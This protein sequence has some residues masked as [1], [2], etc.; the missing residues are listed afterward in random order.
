MLQRAARF[1]PST[2]DAE[3]RT[4][5]LVWST[6][7]GV[8]RRD[9]MTGE[10]FIEELTMTADAV[11]LSRLNAG[12]PLLAAH[13]QFALDGTLGVVER[14]WIDGGEGR[15]T[16][17]FSKR[18][19]VEDVLQD[20]RDGILRNVSVGYSVEE[21]QRER[22]G[23]T[24]V[25][26]AVRWTPMEIS[27]VPVPADAKAQVRS[28][29]EMITAQH[30]DG[31]MPDD[32]KTASAG[33]DETRVAEQARATQPSPDE[34]RAQERARIASFEAPVVT[35]RKAGL[36][37]AAL[38]T[39]RQS[40][41]E[42]G[43]NAD[44]LQA[45]LFECLAKTRA[46]N[47][48]AAAAPAA[49]IPPV[50]TVQVGHSYDDPTVIVDAMATAIAARSMDVVRRSVGDG[51]W[52]DYASLRPSEMLMELAQARGER[53]SPRDRTG[54]IERAFHTTSDF[55]LLLENAGNKMLEAGYSLADPSYR[56][57][58]ARRRFND[59]KPHSFL[60][61]GDYP[62]PEVLGE[63]AEIKIGTMSEKR[64]QITPRTHARG[65]MVTRQMLVNDDLGAFTDFSAMIGRRIA[66]YENA[67]AYAL[68]NTA[69]GDGP[70]L[71]EGSAAVFTTGRNNKAGSATAVTAAALG[72]GFN[73]IMGQTS[74]DG[75]KLNLAPRFLVCSLSQR[76]VAQQLAA[77]SVVPS[78]AGNVNVF[79]GSFEVVADANIPNHRWYLFADPAAA[80]VY[81]YGYVGDAEGPMM[82]QGEVMGRDGIRIDVI[83]DLAYGA[84]D[85]RGGWF[86][87]GAAPA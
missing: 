65:I 44:Q 74:L 37:D 16:V 1:A 32:V 40:A 31:T 39:L 36:D 73:G 68:V 85:F 28:S 33:A 17:R 43:W 4:V 71:S 35:A 27:L 29:D 42:Q 25:R 2:F 13:D 61:A 50:R 70:P 38:N 77:N 15:A 26:R 87:A 14:A 52:R 86:N 19:A 67:Q 83:V 6:G 84:I 55:P 23:E 5:D 51:Q 9:W 58:F 78:A 60:T 75:L 41:I 46:V 49:D 12:A 79:A 10:S 56:R 21:W 34:V 47:E 45:R 66:D 80:P 53:V 8:T 54:L 18:A 11:D 20:V 24:Q 72:T 69:N 7:A 22:R 48:A 62:A 3:A 30:G 64:E 76:F 63:G 82:R 81:V 59:F 57:F